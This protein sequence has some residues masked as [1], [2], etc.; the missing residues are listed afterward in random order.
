MTDN[1]VV[2]LASKREE[3]IEKEKEKEEEFDVVKYFETL[4]ADI[5]KKQAKIVKLQLIL[6]EQVENENVIHYSDAF[7]DSIPEKIGLLE[8][9]KNIIF[10][11]EDGYDD[12]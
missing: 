4:I 1:N 6:V 9:A 11:N 7:M 5:K 3:K 12:D 10:H 2:S 8:C